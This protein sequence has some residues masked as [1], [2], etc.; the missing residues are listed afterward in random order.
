MEVFSLDIFSLF[1][2][3][4]AC[5]ISA[6][7]IVSLSIKLRNRKK[8]IAACEAADR[9]ILHEEIDDVCLKDEIKKTLAVVFGLFVCPLSWINVWFCSYAGK[10][11]KFVALSSIIF[12][13]FI[14]FREIENRQA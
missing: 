2:I 9:I 7:R 12:A 1:L 4:I 8:E 6:I 14:I 5:L 13:F 10:L 3:A 11:S